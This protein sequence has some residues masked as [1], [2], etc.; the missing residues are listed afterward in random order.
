M[1][2]FRPDNLVGYPFW[3]V[4]C[5]AIKFNW[6]IWIMAAGSAVRVAKRVMIHR[7]KMKNEDWFGEVQFW[8]HGMWPVEA[9]Q[10]PGCT[11]CRSSQ[12]KHKS[13]T[14]SLK[15]VQL[16]L[17]VSKLLSW[18]AGLALAE[19]LCYAPGSR[20]SVRHV[21]IKLFKSP[22]GT[23]LGTHVSCGWSGG[24]HRTGVLKPSTNAEWVS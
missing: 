15:L 8:S 1:I 2:L 24:D 10:H 6:I 4:T 13:S 11:Y 17:E 23:V 21:S 9:G 16:E 14:S 19:I 12:Y 20:T 5:S 18:F 3:Y 7:W 22:K